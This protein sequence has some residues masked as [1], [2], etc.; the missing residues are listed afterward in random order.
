MLATLRNRNFALLWTAGLI[1][2]AGDWALQ[3][4]LPIYVYVQTRSTLATGI[5]FMTA[6]LPGLLFGSVAGVFADRWNRRRLMVAAN[7]LSAACLL[8]LLL[9]TSSDT[10]WIVYPVA[11]IAGTIEQFFTP[12]ERA[13]LPALVGDELLVPANALSA[14]NMNASRLIGPPL[15]GLVAGVWGLAGVALVDSASFLLAALLLALIRVAPVSSAPASAG[16]SEG[17]TQ[18]AGVLHE[19]I[20][21][22]R[23]ILHSRALRV[24]LAFTLITSFGEGVFGTLL[25]PFVAAVLHGGAPELGYLMGGQAVGGLLGSLIVGRVAK[26][27]QPRALI[28]LGAMGLGLGDLVIFNYPR[29]YPQVAP[30]IVF[31]AAVGIPAVCIGIGTNTLVQRIVGDAYRGRVF[32]TSMAVMALAM[33]GGAATAGAFGDRLGILLVLNIQGGVYTL[34]GV[35]ALL[36]LGTTAHPKSAS[37]SPTAL[38]ADVPAL[39]ER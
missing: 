5:M 25:P 15:G 4:G 17:N 38:A 8:P 33:L 29:L 22:L 34:A 14:L 23:L 36:L 3:I 13:L 27:A 31:F 9:V 11:F 20:E 39:A 30:G 7:L 37:A 12:A 16:V 6:L 24:L 28:G 1:S 10:L 19:W 35:M 32:A 26:G 2:L 21:G 18:R